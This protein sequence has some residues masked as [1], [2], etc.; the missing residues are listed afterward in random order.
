[1]SQEIVIGIPVEYYR[2]EN[3]PLIYRPNR[4]NPVYAVL[5]ILGFGIVSICTLYFTFT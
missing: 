4:P 3:E 2:S 5:C 1:M